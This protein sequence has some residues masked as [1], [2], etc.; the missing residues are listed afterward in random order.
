MALGLALGNGVMLGSEVRAGN[1][2][3]VG[4]GAVGAMGVWRRTKARAV[5]LLVGETRGRGEGPSVGGAA[6]SVASAA[7]MVGRGES[8]T[9][10]VRGGGGVGVRRGTPMLQA[11]QNKSNA[12][13]IRINGR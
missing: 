8:V 9:R 3:G 12:G 6:V 1:W 4:D 10:G 11:P 13:M 5:G 2:L 7:T